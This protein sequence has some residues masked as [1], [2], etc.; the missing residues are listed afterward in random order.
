MLY[1]WMSKTAFFRNFPHACGLVASTDR[2]LCQGA[3]VRGT[4]DRYCPLAL[5]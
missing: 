5:G 4:G 3:L 2:P 1:R